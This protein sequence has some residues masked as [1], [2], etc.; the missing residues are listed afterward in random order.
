MLDHSLISTANQR[1]ADRSEHKDFLSRENL[2]QM[3]NISSSLLPFLSPLPLLS[4]KHVQPQPIP[5]SVPAQ[6]IITV[7]RTSKI[8][9][10]GPQPSLPAEQ[11]A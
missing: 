3:T 10:S 9:R 11:P 7:E 6:R 4:F 5:T 1:S 2:Q 8:T